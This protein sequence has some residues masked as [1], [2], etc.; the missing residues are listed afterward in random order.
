[1]VLFRE[2]TVRLIYEFVMPRNIIDLK[3]EGEVE[4]LEGGWGKCKK[5][6]QRSNNS[7]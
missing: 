6:R 7:T 3:G 2:V 1:M 4:G 5:K